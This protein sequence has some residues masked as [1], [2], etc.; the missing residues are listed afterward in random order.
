MANLANRGTHFPIT[1]KATKT[2][3]AVAAKNAARVTVTALIRT[4]AQQISNNSGVRRKRLQIA[5]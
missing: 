3:E 4:Y 1:S 2:A 5:N